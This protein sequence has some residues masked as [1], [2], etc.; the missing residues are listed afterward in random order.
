MSLSIHPRQGYTRRHDRLANG[1][2][3]KNT[4]NIFS[5]ENTDDFEEIHQRH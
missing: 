1:H 2:R 4:P 3:Q 5:D